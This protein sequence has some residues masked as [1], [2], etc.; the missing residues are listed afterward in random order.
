MD[1][2]KQVKKSLFLSLEKRKKN[3]GE[4]ERESLRICVCNTIK[5]ELRQSANQEKAR[6]LQRFFKTGKGEYGE[7]DVFLGVVVPETR[8][9]AKKHFMEIDFAGVERLLDS[10]MHE[11]RL[12]GLL[13]LVLKF[14]K[15]KGDEKM[16]KEIFDFYI[17]HAKLANNWDL[18][19]L[20]A[21]AISGGYLWEACESG[22]ETEKEILYRFAKSENLWERRIAV[23]STFAFIREKSFSD[24][25]RIAEML[26][27]D[28]HDLIHKAVGWMLREIGKRDKKAEE[29]FLE[30]HCAKMPRTM[31]RYAIEKFPQAERE[32]YL[33]GFVQ[34]PG[35]HK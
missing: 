16:R 25:F 15:A 12:C 30:K 6:L 7:G 8:R 5:K 33:R 22:N 13:I 27:Q 18:V 11:D 10:K 14:N 21:P 32:K 1:T 34:N 23:L 2:A 3:A 4:K 20:S 9:V 19:D 24:S 28:K 35:S 31:L 26:L 17:S 29:N